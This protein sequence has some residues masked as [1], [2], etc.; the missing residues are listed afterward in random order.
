MKLESLGQ[1]LTVVA[2]VG[3]LLGLVLVAYELRQETQATL[4][5]TQVNLLNILH[6]RDNWLADEQ[7]ASV[8]VKAETLD[9]K[10]TVVEARQHAEWLYGK[11][12]V[13]EH[14]FERYQAGLLSDDYW[15]GWVGGCKALV[16]Y[17]QAR[18]VWDERRSWYGPE[19]AK[20][21]DAHAIS[22]E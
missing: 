18:S 13:C 9:P 1:W 5:E 4:G 11:F 15:A 2:N 14:V 6:E 8:V 17:P 19:F 10:L 12:N 22:F 16:E 7:F 3:V 20:F 21:L